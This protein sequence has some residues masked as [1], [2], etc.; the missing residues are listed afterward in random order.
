MVC[1]RTAKFLWPIVI[2][3]WLMMFWGNKVSLPCQFQ[4]WDLAGGEKIAP[5]HLADTLKYRLKVGER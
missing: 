5:T 3:W 1:A 4:H 2:T